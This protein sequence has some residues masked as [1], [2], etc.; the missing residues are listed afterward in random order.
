MLEKHHK[1]QPKPKM[2]DELKA[3]L[4]NAELS[5]L[6]EVHHYAK[7]AFTRYELNLLTL[8][9]IL[10]FLIYSAAKAAS[11]FN[12]L[13]LLFYTVLSVCS[14]SIHLQLCVLITTKPAL[15]RATN[16]LPVKTTPLRNGEWE[17]SRLN[18][19]ISSF[20]DVIQQNSVV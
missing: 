17:M 9:F 19:I 11:A 18:S 3:A 6:E 13:T 15:F 7:S 1:L 12:E 4:Q 5:S 20:S 14:N 2:I 10:P 16:R 8:T